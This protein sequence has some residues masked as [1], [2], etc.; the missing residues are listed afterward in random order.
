MAASR[1]RLLAQNGF[2]W[3]II[4][5]S[6]AEVIDQIKHLPPVERAQV[7]RFLVENEDPACVGKAAV[8]L[9]DDGLPVI[10]ANGGVITS[11]LVHELESLT[12]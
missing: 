3:I 8:A 4:A 1:K 2:S 12:P 9:A 6:A 5:M 10:R 7:V 11:R